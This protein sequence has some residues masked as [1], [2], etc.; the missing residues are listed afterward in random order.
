MASTS[1]PLFEKRQEQRRR[2]LIATDCWTVRL[3]PDSGVNFYENSDSHEMS[4][5]DPFSSEI[6]TT[7]ADAVD[8][9]ENME[10]NLDEHERLAGFS[11]APPHNNLGNDECEYSSDRILNFLE[12]EKIEVTEEDNIKVGPVTQTLPQR[13]TFHYHS[14]PYTPSPLSPPPSLPPAAQVP[15]VRRPEARDR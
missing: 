11:L 6:E 15:R 1:D 4:W 8:Q 12:K 5:T 3:H 13:C 9:V 2:S 10:T 7:I 14:L